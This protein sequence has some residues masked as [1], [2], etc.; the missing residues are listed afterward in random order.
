M[1]GQ[2]LAR[3]I[4]LAFWLAVTMAPFA[5]GA[6]SPVMPGPSPIGSVGD[7][8]KLE[9][10]TK[11]AEQACGYVEFAGTRGAMLAE[12]VKGLADA[13]KLV[14][15]HERNFPNTKAEREHRWKLS[16]RVRRTGGGK[17]SDPAHRAL[18][19]QV[20]AWA[21]FVGDVASWN[22]QPPAAC[23]KDTRTS[24]VPANTRAT[25]EEVARATRSADLPQ[26]LLLALNLGMPEFAAPSNP[27][28]VSRPRTNRPLL[29]N[30]S[31]S[32]AGVV[33]RPAEQDY[34]DAAL[35][36][37]G[38]FSG[39]RIA[40][41]I[42]VESITATAEVTNQFDR[43]FAPDDSSS[44]TIDKTNT[45]IA[46]DMRFE[47]GNGPFRPVFGMGTSFGSQNSDPIVVSRT[48]APNDFTMVYIRN[49]NPN[50][51]NVHAGLK[52]ELYQGRGYTVS[53]VPNIGLYRQTY[54]I[55]LSGAAGQPYAATEKV[56]NWTPAFGV[57]AQIDVAAMQLYLGYRAYASGGDGNV[58]GRTPF[59]ES[60]VDTSLEFESVIGGARI[61][62]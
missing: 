60:R 26:N 51:F 34:W 49:F 48:Y 33:G 61:R 4:G 45:R 50:T 28:T 35:R 23:P 17:L 31:V 55:Q 22:W 38:E 53:L 46:L 19:E 6:A 16:A 59:A 2:P 52:A 58:S 57:E 21:R 3:C 56:V 30:T 24:Q 43:F 1:T 10:L 12:A 62:F 29:N 42:G 54:E 14:E 37:A 15:A 8:G 5:A 27:A 7:R 18:V 20:E 44:W 25:R 40:A 11:S 39:F 9:E 32:T 47:F 36:Y 41:G 13:W